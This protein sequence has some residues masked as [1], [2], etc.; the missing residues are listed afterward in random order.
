[1]T[2]NQHF[3]AW[4]EELRSNKIQQ[5]SG[6][7]H[8]KYET[9]AGPSEEMCCLGVCSA[10]HAD[11]LS[12]L[13]RVYD[14]VVKYNNMGSYPEKEVLTFMGSPDSHI[15]AKVQG[16]S[17]LVSRDDDL[18]SNRITDYNYFK[19]INADKISVDI[20]NDNGFSFA[21]IADLLE[22]EFLGDSQEVANA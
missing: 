22:K 3:V 16:Y 19:D 10:L 15:E 7:L 4:L 21:E 1:M 11:K 20:L 18:M 8:R 6:F 17:V 12:T 5:G 9:G 13:I 14:T 2:V